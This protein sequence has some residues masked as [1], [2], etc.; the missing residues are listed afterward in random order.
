V[1]DIL[2]VAAL[3]SALTRVKNILIKL[4]EIK[5][6]GNTEYFLGVKIEREHKQVK[7]TQE[8][9]TRGGLER[10]GMLENKPAPCYG[11]EHPRGGF[12]RTRDTTPVVR[13]MHGS[14]L[15][16][17]ASFTFNRTLLPT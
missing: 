4:Y 9:Y 12:L 2:V 5:D 11:A 13:N 17:S 6:L 8:S 16:H 7:L 3:E 1:D 14:F 10:Y 15:V